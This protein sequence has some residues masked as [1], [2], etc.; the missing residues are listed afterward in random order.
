MAEPITHVLLDIEGTTC[1][2][3]FVGDTLFPYAAAHL[4][5]FL[6]AHAESTAVRPL[7]EEVREAWS[8]DPQAGQTA[9]GGTDEEEAGKTPGMAMNESTSNK[10]K[11]SGFKTNEIQISETKFHIITNHEVSILADYLIK[12]IN[13][14]RKLPALKELQGMIWEEGYSRGE[15]KAPLFPEVA[16]ALKQWQ[17]A[18]LLLG[19]YSSGSIT[20]QQLL[21]AHTTDGDLKPMFSAWFD[22]RTGAKQAISSYHSIAKAWG[23]EPGSIL[24][25]S[26]SIAEVAAAQGAGMAVAFSNREG[27]PHRNSRGLLQVTSLVQL[28]PLLRNGAPAEPKT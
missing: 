19:V 4:R 18:G 2:V 9:W 22:T 25:V 12:L 16:T 27:N 21:Y 24:F 28:N 20:A 17:Q 1:P 26:D 10:T 3:A 7:L 14:D 15:I 23:A 11:T 6:L 13:H 5:A 8:L